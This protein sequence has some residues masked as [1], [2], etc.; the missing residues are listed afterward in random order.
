MAANITRYKNLGTIRP[1]T[2][3]ETDGEGGYWVRHWSMTHDMHALDM[4]DARGI[5]ETQEE[6]FL[7]LERAVR[8]CEIHGYKVYKP[9]DSRSFSR[10]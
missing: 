1:A 2:K 5:L 10:G 7:E 8:L 6:E 4:E 9:V 3:A